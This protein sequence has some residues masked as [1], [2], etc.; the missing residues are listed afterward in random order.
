M[1]KITV[2]STAEAIRLGGAVTVPTT[3]IIRSPLTGLA[4]GCFVAQPRLRK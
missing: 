3:F 4:V 2:R 1:K